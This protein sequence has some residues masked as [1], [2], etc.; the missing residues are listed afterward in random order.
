V[1]KDQKAQKEVKG[2]RSGRG[3]KKIFLVEYTQKKGGAKRKDCSGAKQ[4]QA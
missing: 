1:N 4:N 3:S 2:R